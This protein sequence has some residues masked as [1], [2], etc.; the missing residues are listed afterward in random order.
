MGA[1]LRKLLHLIPGYMFF[2]KSEPVDELCNPVFAEMQ[3]LVKLRNWH[4][5]RAKQL[6]T[7]LRTMSDQFADCIE[8]QGD[9]AK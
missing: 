5:E 7:K 9:Y 1:K 8:R 4:E 2:V 6:T 3:Q